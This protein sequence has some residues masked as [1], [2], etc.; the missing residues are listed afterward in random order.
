[1]LSYVV[2]NFLFLLISMLLT[3]INTLWACFFDHHTGWINP[4]TSCTAYT[5]LCSGVSVTS[6]TLFYSV[7]YSLFAS[8]LSSLL[9]GVFKS[10][11]QLRQ[12]SKSD[13][14]S[15][16]LSSSLSEGW[17][18]IDLIACTYSTCVCPAGRPFA[19]YAGGRG[20]LSDNVNRAARPC[21]KFD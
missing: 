9:F 12:F 1:M 8:Q 2:L 17:W 10:P 13:I 6:L 20:N 16:E 18:S 14:L 15:D 21:W 4:G 5:F 3:G 7:S 19:A 11:F